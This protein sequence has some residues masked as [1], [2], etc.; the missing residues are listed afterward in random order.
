MDGLV[1]NVASMVAGAVTN[2]FGGEGRHRAGAHGNFF[3]RQIVMSKEDG[4]DE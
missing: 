4:H 2:P 1:I 3:T